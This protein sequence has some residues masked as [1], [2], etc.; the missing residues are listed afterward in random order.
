VKVYQ[1]IQAG[2]IYI[3][4]NM[5]GAVVG[6]QPFGG[7]RL[8][9]TG[10]KAG[11]PFYLYRLVN[12]SINPLLQY[13]TNS[14]VVVN[15][16][17]KLNKFVATLEEYGFNH[18]EQQELFNYAEYIRLNLLNLKQ[19][20][21]PG[22]TGEHNFMFFAKRGVIACFAG[23]TLD[24]AKQIVCA[25]ATDNRVVLPQDL[26]TNIFTKLSAI[27]VT[28]VKDIGHAPEINLALIAKSYFKKRELR[29]D[30]AKRE[31]NLVI[32]VYEKSDGQYDLY[33]LMTE[34]A[35]SINTTATGGNVQLISVE[36][37]VV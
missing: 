8:S 17:F 21:L 10:P 36:D 18:V 31:G 16:L 13:R 5:I 9:G 35:V 23:N 28:I 22:P 15:D 2:N 37:M 14:E 19:I 7:E 30:L 25:L 34:R 4:R 11:G 24:Y 3:N 20:E 29:E 32:N 12:S 26:H 27:G 33:L 6:V 1:N